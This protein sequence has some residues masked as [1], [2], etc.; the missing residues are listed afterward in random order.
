MAKNKKSKALTT[1]IDIS[2]YRFDESKRKNIPPAGLAAHGVMEYAPKQRFYYD[3]HLPPVLRFDNTGDNDKLPELLEKAKKQILSLSEVLLLAEALKKQ[4]PWLEWAGKRE[5]KWF[6]V[7]PVALNIHERISTQAILR[8]A[9]RENIQRDLFADPEMEYREAV[10]FYKHD[11]D[12][13]N[14]LILGDSLQVMASLAYRENLSGKVQMIFFDP[15]YGIKFSSNFQPEVGKRDVKDQDNHLTR[16]A[17]M[18]KAFRDTWKLGLHSYLSYMRDR[19]ITAKKLLKDSGSIMV[20][21]GIEN[22]HVVRN[23]LDDVF[24][25][26][27]FQSEI[28]FKKNLPL[29]TKGLPVINDFILWYSKDNNHYWWNS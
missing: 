18:V 21:I 26:E 2:D 20:Q 11:M 15:P 5:R 12:W 7:D 29:G 10:R 19:L 24:G 1:D 6:E 3:S 27:N 8:I 22:V 23:L 17:E 9:K 14:R 25:K 28:V 16:E 13:A 4:E